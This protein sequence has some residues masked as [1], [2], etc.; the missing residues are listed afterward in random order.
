MDQSSLWPWLLSIDSLS[1]AGSRSH[2]RGRVVLT[3][4]A[5]PFYAPLGLVWHIL[6]NQ[7]LYRHYLGL[8]YSLWMTST[9]RRVWHR[10]SMCTLPSISEQVGKV[11]R[12]GKGS[13][14]V[15][16]DGNSDKFRLTVVEVDSVA[17]FR[18]WESPSFKRFVK[19]WPSNFT[20][21]FRTVDWV[22]ELTVVPRHG[23]LLWRT[24]LSLHY[25][26]DVHISIIISVR[27]FALSRSRYWEA[28]ID[29]RILTESSDAT[30]A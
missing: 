4:F 26:W 6:V 29:R 11:G 24:S 15:N 18:F 1:W 7:S 17:V 25:Y 28:A 12:V 23:F 19:Q 5:F 10:S 9:C 14:I 27:Y 8:C 20:K 30:G 2:F 22:F 3:P 21:L 13:W 16:N